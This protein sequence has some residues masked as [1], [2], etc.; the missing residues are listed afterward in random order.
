[1]TL[2]FRTLRT[3]KD[4]LFFCHNERKKKKKSCQIWKEKKEK[5]GVEKKKFST[6]II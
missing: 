3:S 6:H 5:R 4:T 2:T 1:M